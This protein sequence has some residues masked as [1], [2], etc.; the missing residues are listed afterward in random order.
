MQK[1]N[2]LTDQRLPSEYRDLA[3]ILSTEI[4]RKWINPLLK[5]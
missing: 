4:V 1:Q 3:T 5:I 2:F